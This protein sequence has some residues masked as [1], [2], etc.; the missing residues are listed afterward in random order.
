MNYFAPYDVENGST[1]RVSPASTGSVTPSVDCSVLFTVISANG[2]T[3]GSIYTTGTDP[4]FIELANIAPVTSTTM[5]GAF[6]YRI[7]LTA[8]SANPQWNTQGYIVNVPRAVASF[9]CATLMPL[10]IDSSNAGQGFWTP[11]LRIINFS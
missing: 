4:S 8:T 9:K 10:T 5:G 6:A 1:A 3:T 11:G 7:Q 2:T